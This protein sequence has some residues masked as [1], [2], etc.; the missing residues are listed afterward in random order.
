MN[1]SIRLTGARELEAALRRHPERVAA[2]TQRA[3]EMSARGLCIAYG[4]HTSPPDAGGET[5]L[6]GYRSRIGKDVARVFPVSTDLAAVY[7]LMLAHAPHLA[8]AWW[9][10]V[11]SQDTKRANDILRLA[12]LPRSAPSAATLKS[13][14]TAAKGRVDRR[15][16]PESL[17][18]PAEQSR[19]AKSQAALV[20]VAKAGWHQA[21]KAI[22]GRVR[23]NL[24]AE[25]GKRSTAEAFP[26]WVRKVSRKIA[27]LG[28]AMVG[29]GRVTIFSN[30]RHA[31]AAIEPRHKAGAEAAAAE[32]FSKAMAAAVSRVTKRFR[33][34]S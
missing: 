24:V 4:K 21:A 13:Y 22:G 3:L 18:R 20:G 14:R 25:D 1:I 34:A 8:G 28:G 29:K 6:N 9:H 27:G 32:T 26:A 31:A 30:V 7:R 11:K 19:L 5:A 10:A 17:A 12:D 16:S 2:T 33:S 15:K 23:I